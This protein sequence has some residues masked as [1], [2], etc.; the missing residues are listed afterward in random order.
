MKIVFIVKSKNDFILYKYTFDLWNTNGHEL[1]Q[2]N[3][4]ITTT[5][6]TRLARRVPLVE[7][8]LLTLPEHLSSPRFFC[9]IRVTRFLILCVCFELRC[10]GRVSSSCSTSGTRRANLVTKVVVIHKWGK[11]REVFMTSETLSWSFVTQKLHNGQFWLRLWYLQTLLNVG[12][13]VRNWN[14]THCQTK[15]QQWYM[16]VC[17][18][19]DIH[20]FCL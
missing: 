12:I 6:V 8:E 2:N 16:K 17:F 15:G 20:V 14:L 9:G 19:S 13:P 7:Q 1:Y 18:R 4:W 10:S 5:F 3:A 11:D